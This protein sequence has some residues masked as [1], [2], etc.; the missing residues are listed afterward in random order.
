LAV[1]LGLAL[2]TLAAGVAASFWF[3]T[4]GRLASLRNIGMRPATIS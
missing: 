2:T 3:D 1:L 4:I